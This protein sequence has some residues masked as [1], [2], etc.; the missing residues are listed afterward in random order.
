MRL[1]VLSVYS[2]RRF[3]VHT[4][5]NCIRSREFILDANFID[6]DNNLWLSAFRESNLGTFKRVTIIVKCKVVLISNV[7]YNVR[8]QDYAATECSTIFILIKFL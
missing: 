7:E 6:A 8:I 1:Y 4:I 3:H 5:R 2:K